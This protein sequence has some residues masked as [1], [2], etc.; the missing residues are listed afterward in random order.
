MCQVDTI[1]PKFYA[2]VHKQTEKFYTEIETYSRTRNWLKWLN[3]TS[4]F[5]LIS[6]TSD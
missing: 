6:I 2:E 3:L 1:K 5:N 4:K